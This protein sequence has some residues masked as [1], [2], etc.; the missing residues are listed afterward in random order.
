MSDYNPCLIIIFNHKYDNNISALEKIYASK[1][2]N[3]FFLVPFYTGNNPRVIPV[4]ESSFYFQGYIAQGY[5]IFYRPE[6][7]HYL[8]IG[9]D[10]ILNPRVN[11]TNYSQ[12]LNLSETSSYIPELIPLHGATSEAVDLAG[13]SHTPGYWSHTPGAVTF[14]ENRKGS[15]IKN[16]LPSYEEAMRSFIKQGIAIKP[17]TYYDIFGPLSFPTTKQAIIETSTKLWTY[18]RTWRLLKAQGQRQQLQLPYPLVRGYSDI[19][20]ISATAIERFCHLCGVFSAMGLFVEIAIPSALVLSTSHIVTDASATLKGEA[21]WLD[22]IAA[23]ERKYNLNL[24]ALF[25]NF[26]DN[27][28]YYHPIKLSRWQQN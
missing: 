16:E 9:D 3:I 23:L 20:V 6:F 5:K 24:N 1:F 25:A 21:L 10:L 27:Q 26:P 28:L 7:T 18:Y 17:L 2:T 11:E 14:Y 15:E 4:Y 8:F 12:L 22:D 19:V 13:P